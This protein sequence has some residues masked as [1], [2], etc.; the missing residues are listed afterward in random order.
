MSLHTAK[1]ALN[2]YLAFR[3]GAELFA[4]DVAQV[5]EILDFTTIT[6]V[7][8]SPAFMRGV[9]NVR[10]SV[11]PVVDLSVKFDTAPTEK[12]LDTRIVVME[13]VQEDQMA[14]VGALADAVHSVIEIDPARIEATPS[15]GR[16]CR[17]DFIKGIG[18]L[19]EQFI[20]ILDVDRIF[21]AD[22]LAE[23]HPAL[24]RSPE[25][26]GQRAA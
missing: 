17:T 23:A 12:T 13:I 22:E 7:P 1:A 10:G 20:I 11:V 16:Q 4:L 8:R 18:K 21:S 19:D 5:R 26:D 2:Q 9:I 24:N 6:K 25:I 3:L 15:V 14:V